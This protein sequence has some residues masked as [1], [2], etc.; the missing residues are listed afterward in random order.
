M[1]CKKNKSVLDAILNWLNRFQKVDDKI[2]N[3]PIFILDDEADQASISNK[4]GSVTPSAINGQIRTLLNSFTNSTYL[5]YTA[6]PYANLL[7]DPKKT[8][9]VGEDLFPK[10]F[11][12]SLPF[13]ENYVGFE[14]VFPNEDIEDFDEKYKQSEKYIQIINDHYDDPQSDSEEGW[15]PHSAHKD[16]SFIPLYQGRQEIPPSLKR[17]V[18]TFLLCSA[19]KGIRRIDELHSSML[20]HV[21]YKNSIQDE[22]KSQIL[23]FVDILKQELPL[24][25]QNN[26]HWKQIKNIWETDLGKI[27]NINNDLNPNEKELSWSKI[28]DKI[29]YPNI[30]SILDR[31]D[32]IQLS[33]TSADILNY[34][35]YEKKGS[36]LIVIGGNKLSRGIT[37]SGLCISYF[38][39]Y[40][41][42][43]LADTITQMARWFGYRDGY[44]DLCRVFLTSELRDVMSQIS[45][46]D[47]EV[48]TQIDLLQSRPDIT[49]DQ[50][51]IYLRSFPGLMVTNKTRMKESSQTFSLR[52]DNH[53]LGV[54]VIKK[55]HNEKNGKL[56]NEF[57]K[58]LN[59]NPDYVN[60]LRS[61]NQ[62]KLKK[63]IITKSHN[64]DLIWRN[65]DF[66]LITD[67]FSK[68]TA[69]P[70]NLKINMEGF[71]KYINQKVDKRNELVKWNVI[72]KSRSQLRKPIVNIGGYEIIPSLRQ[73]RKENLKSKIKYTQLLEVYL[74]E[75]MQNYF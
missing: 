65:I 74:L 30:D 42:Q 62:V 60:N 47:E 23:E 34:K 35:E 15:M 75:V 1:I 49:P 18:Y 44:Q 26:N 48:R 71:I 73:V 58:N 70:G 12:V 56:F 9:L 52:Y 61:E 21:T 31:L 8:Q 6:T 25:N 41:K 10:S 24:N 4:P 22:V 27:E 11:I 17:A 63:D 19:V 67:F 16:N 45:G 20:V 37:L 13:P 33:N 72:L 50:Y 3:I 46:L 59:R 14:D 29:I 68:Y 66:K 39:R 2:N 53:S 69:H 38:S 51:P 64:R 55:S 28:V 43:R 7:I 32:C 36:V 54:K 57:I 40:A 5:A